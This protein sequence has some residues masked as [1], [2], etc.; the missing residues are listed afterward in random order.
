M[1]AGVVFKTEGLKNMA[2]LRTHLL[3]AA[4]GL[5][6][7]VSF[8]TGA[9]ATAI[10]LDPAASNLP[11]GGVLDGTTG[12]FTAT[13]ANIFSRA[14]VVLTPLGGSNFGF[15]E[16]ANYTVTSFDTGT[17]NVGVN[18]QL[19]GTVT[20]SG[21]LTGLT[22]I[23][24]GI[25][26][27]V[28]SGAS[29]AT[30]NVNLFGASGTSVTFAQPTNLSDSGITGT[31]FSLGTGSNVPS[32]TDAA[33]LAL[34]GTEAVVSLFQG[35]ASFTPAAGTTPTGIFQGPIPFDIN[36]FANVSGPG[37]PLPPATSEFAC[38]SDGT[39]NPSGLDTCIG[40]GTAALPGS[41]VI[42]FDS[43]PV[44]E[45]TTIAV[46]G[47]SLLGLVGLRRRKMA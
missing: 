36:L 28:G 5:A 8:A 10:T 39:A 11:A 6:L 16:I 34:T 17:H 22:Q 47:V 2:S 29:L 35:V 41:G 45:P 46:L 20:D 40:I 9:S 23:A 13:S 25:V 43:V 27:G 32:P 3:T 42:S 37:N 18:Y 33:V 19:F 4:A 15:Q 26:V 24:P 14:E 1:S 21:V 31:G 7:A 38:N 12:P 30:F 44:P